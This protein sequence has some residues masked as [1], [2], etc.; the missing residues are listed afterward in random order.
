M[1]YVLDINPTETKKAYDIID[2]CFDIENNFFYEF[3]DDVKYWIDKNC[4]DCELS[5]DN[6]DIFK[7]YKI[8]F[9]NLNDMSL[10]KLRWL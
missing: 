1:W 8:F 5:Y 10:F 6:D 7:E 9:K 2:V 4:I 3:K